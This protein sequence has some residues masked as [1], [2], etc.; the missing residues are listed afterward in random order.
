M[1]VGTI[2]GVDSFGAGVTVPVAGSVIGSGIV[3][4]GRALV[5]KRAGS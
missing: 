4:G 3:R 1:G 5:G 2:A